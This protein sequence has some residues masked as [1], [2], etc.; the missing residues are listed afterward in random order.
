MEK[1]PVKTCIETFGLTVGYKGNE[2]FQDLRLNLNAGELVCFMGPNGVGKSTLIRTLAGLQSPLS[3]QITYKTSQSQNPDDL[4]LQLAVVLTDRITAANMTAAEVISFGRY[5][6]LNWTAQLTTN[7]NEIIN[8]VLAKIRIEHLHNKKL[9][10]L[11]DGQVQ[12]VMIARAVVQDTPIILLDEPTA[13]LDLNNRLEIMALLRQLAHKSNKAILVSTHELDLA[14]QTADVIWLGGPDK[15][16]TRGIPEDLILDGTFDSIFQ[17][18][19][20]DLKTGRVHHEPHRGVS[21]NLKG[22]GHEYLWTKNALERNGFII[23]EHGAAH[24]VKIDQAGGGLQWT[25]NGELK[26]SSLERLL[27]FLE[28]KVL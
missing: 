17:F 7:D 14:I 9:Y 10:E 15:K 5:P 19:G 8:Q 3:G 2:L 20:F 24:D 22:M 26:F 13:H 11:S 28:S 21:I 23:C 4:P 6:Y 18:K 25:L 16:I 27:E 1:A 12:M